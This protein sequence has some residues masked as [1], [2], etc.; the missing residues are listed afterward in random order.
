MLAAGLLGWQAIQPRSSG[1]TPS[2]SVQAGSIT[3][4]G[5]GATMASLHRHKGQTIELC[6]GI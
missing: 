4:P 1:L 5:L 6:T 3:P 2:L